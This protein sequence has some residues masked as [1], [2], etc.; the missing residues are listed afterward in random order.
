MSA[1]AALAKNRR[2]VSAALDGLRVAY[3]QIVPEDEPALANV[4]T[5]SDYKRLGSASRARDWRP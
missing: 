2:N 1:R 5:P 4:N 3:Y